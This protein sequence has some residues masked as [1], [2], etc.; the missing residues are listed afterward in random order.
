MSLSFRHVGVGSQF[1][2]PAGRLGGVLL[3][4][5]VLGEGQGRVER[6]VADVARPGLV[7][8]PVQEADRQGMLP[9]GQMDL[10][11]N[12]WSGKGEN[13]GGGGDVGSSGG[14]VLSIHPRRGEEV[15]GLCC[16]SVV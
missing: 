3:A 4:E 12:C 8:I 9:P 5:V 13:I 1:G 6:Q 10:C 16:Q 2:Q 14:D 11:R 15:I 7:R